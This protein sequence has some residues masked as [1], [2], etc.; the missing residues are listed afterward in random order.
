MQQTDLID[1]Q[2]VLAIAVMYEPVWM[3]ETERERGEGRFMHF[4]TKSERL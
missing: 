4:R 2:E 3:V 1:N